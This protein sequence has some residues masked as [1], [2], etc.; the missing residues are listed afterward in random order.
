M[1]VDVLQHLKQR[2]ALQRGRHMSIVS[3]RAIE[4]REMPR[5]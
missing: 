1:Y 3:K 4:K 5:A 2:H